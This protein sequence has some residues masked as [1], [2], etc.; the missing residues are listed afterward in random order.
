MATSAC[1]R[2]CVAPAAPAG[3]GTVRLPRCAPA[4]L[5]FRYRARNWPDSLL[6][7][8]ERRRW[9]DYRRHRLQAEDGLSGGDLLAQY[10][11]EIA[12]L[13]KHASQTMPQASG[14]CW[15][16][17][18]AW[19]DGHCCGPRLTCGTLWFP[20]PGSRRRS[21]KSGRRRD[22]GWS[23][24]GPDRLLLVLW[25]FVVAGPW[26]GDQRHPQLVAAGQYGEL[27]RFVDSSNC[28]SL[29]RRSSRPGSPGHAAR[30]GNASG[31]A[32]IGGCA[33]IAQ[34]AIDDGLADR[35]APPLLHGSAGPAARRSMPTGNG[36]QS[37]PP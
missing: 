2:R 23:L 37:M 5:L 26:L 3:Q 30:V 18:K 11:A 20:N 13:R 6:P 19:G 4:G 12:A 10:H 35:N 32:A 27:W 1:W 33:M 25:R 16:G 36:A 29:A 22:A 14:P 17:C 21:K 28:A 24:A 31:P 7:S 15:A 9:D 34:P 8:D